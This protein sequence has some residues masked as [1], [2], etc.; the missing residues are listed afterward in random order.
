MKERKALLEDAKAAT[1]AALEEGVV[2]GGGVALLRC[3]K[4]VEKLVL[5]G[6]ERLGADIIKNVLDY[7]FDRSPTMPGSMEL[8]LSIACVA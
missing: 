5:E 6:D 4:V 3:E 7:P 2:P 1:A 8:S